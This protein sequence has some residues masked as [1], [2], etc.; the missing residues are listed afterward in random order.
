MD[1]ITLTIPEAA[2]AL[3]IGINSAYEAAKR[4]EIPTLK[5]GRRVVVPARALQALLDGCGEP[6]RHAQD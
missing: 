5:I 1:R 6:A 2:K 3:G 4:G